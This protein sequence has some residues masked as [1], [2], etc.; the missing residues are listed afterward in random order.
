MA[1]KKFALLVFTIITFST[2]SIVADNDTNSQSSSINTYKKNTYSP[3]SDFFSTYED[4]PF[5]DISIPEPSFFERTK[6]WIIIYIAQFIFSA[7]S[8]YQSFKKHSLKT[9]A[10]MKAQIKKIVGYK[11]YHAQ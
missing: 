1:I 2:L 11:K 8:R 5:L 4:D 6:N 3:S 7:N 9:L 10:L